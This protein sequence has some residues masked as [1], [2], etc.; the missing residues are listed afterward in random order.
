MFFAKPGEYEPCR[1]YSTGHMILLTITLVTVMMLIQVTKNFDKDRVKKI[2]KNTTIL[3]WIMEIIK[4]I[5]NLSIGH[6]NNPNHYVPLYYCSIIL[7]AGLFSSYGKG[8][9]KKIG[10]IFI[11]TGAIIGGAFFLSTPNTSLTMYPMFHYISI[12]SFVF[13]GAMVYLG[14]LVNITGY[15]ELKFKDIRYYAVLITIMSSV[16]YV[17]NNILG[18]NFMFI[19]QNFPNTP[20][21]IIF[22]WAGKY[23]TIV[24]CLLQIILP[25]L[26]VYTI[27]KLVRVCII[28]I[29]E[30]SNLN[31]IGST[32]GMD[33]TNSEEELEKIKIEV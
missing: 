3:L 32:D 2:I 21:E 13:H 9:F 25:F 11:S 23:F 12:Q 8:L 30:Y 14:I 7:Y 18:T 4:I 29:K 15:V 31:N 10:D 5:F 16:S 6:G 33:D 17:V 26:I 20:V 1:M 19:S 27:N 24:M 22:N 28:K